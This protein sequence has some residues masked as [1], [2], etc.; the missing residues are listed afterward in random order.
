M[1]ND[2]LFKNFD[3]LTNKK[4]KLINHPELTPSAFGY[5][6]K[7]NAHTY[8]RE[9]FNRVLSPGFDSLTH[10]RSV[11]LNRPA[12]PHIAHIK[13]TLSFTLSVLLIRAVFIE[14]KI[15]F[16]SGF[17]VFVSFFLSFFVFA[18]HP[19]TNPKLKAVQPTFCSHLCPVEQGAQLGFATTVIKMVIYFFL[20][21]VAV[22]LT[23]IV[24]VSI[25]EEF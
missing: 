15:S 2:F 4:Q 20:G 24:Y 14:G 3:N 12:C 9:S 13:R 21:R 11:L 6:K 1:R 17:L 8:R 16:L 19:C 25:A 22:W 5:T 23:K 10:P 18:T 7:K